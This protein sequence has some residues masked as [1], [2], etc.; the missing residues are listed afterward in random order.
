MAGVVELRNYLQNI[1]GLGADAQGLERAN[2]IIEEGISSMD[3]FADFDKDDMITLCT[4]VRKPGGTIPDPA[5]PGRTISRT[6]TGTQ[7]EQ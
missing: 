4:S 2:A 1:I 5:N 7:K 3:D 6:I